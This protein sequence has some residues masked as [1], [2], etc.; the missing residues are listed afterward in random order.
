MK[1]ATLLNV[2]GVFMKLFPNPKLQHCHENKYYV[3][4]YR[5]IAPL[6]FTGSRGRHWPKCQKCVRLV[7]VRHS[8][9]VSS[10]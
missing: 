7:D 2:N 6:L 9:A 3:S 4:A 10:F 1:V 8:K 5:K